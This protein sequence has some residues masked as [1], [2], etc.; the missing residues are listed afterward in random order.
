LTLSKVD[1]AELDGVV[2]GNVEG[3]HETGDGL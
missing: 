2:D 3:C 1:Q